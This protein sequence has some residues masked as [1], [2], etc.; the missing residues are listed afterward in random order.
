MIP[1][2]IP[3][4]EP[5]R[6]AELR[7]LKLLDTPPEARFDHL[8]ELAATVF[9][10]PIAY[11]ALVDSE[12]QWL[13]AKCGLTVDQTG[14]DVSFCGHTIL[15]DEPLIVADARQDERFHDN[16]LV[17]GQPRIRFYAGYPLAGPGGHNVGTLCI[18]DSR[19]RTLSPREQQILERIGVLAKEELGM[20]DVIRAQ[21]DL[22]EA[23]SAL[24]A[25]QSRLS[26]E[27]AEAARYVRSQFPPRLEGAVR[28]DWQYLSCSQL[29]G[30]S[31]GYHWLD[32]SHLA[33]YLLDVCGHGVGASLLSVAAQSA[34]RRGAL[35]DVS[36]L[37][38]GEVLAGLNRTFP[39]EENDD[40]FFTVWYGVYDV[41]SRTLRYASG[42]HPP[43]IVFASPGGEPVWLEASGLAIG[44]AADARYDTHHC[45][46]RSGNRMYLYSDGAYEIPLADRGLLGLAG[47][48]QLLAKPGQ[49]TE[50]RLDQV[51]QAIR[52]MHA[53]GELCDDV[54]LVELEFA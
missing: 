10:A 38:P 54:S 26:Y 43:A 22:L 39:M 33:A 48:A 49:R 44:I 46:L 21:Q 29:G 19:P 28:A 25:A 37:E 30:D 6:L 36:F 1:A 8:V 34:L 23:K 18:A 12:R 11:I 13:K 27:L 32:A 4:D 45:R 52:G 15:Q 14:R 41:A 53:G 3:A 16:P 35:P 40:R 24:L 9:D 7:A 50:R 17:V 51:L 31:F 47:L 20:H 2:V 5:Q 42:G